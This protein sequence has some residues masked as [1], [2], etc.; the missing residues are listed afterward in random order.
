MKKTGSSSKNHLEWDFGS[1][2]EEEI[3][4]CFHYE[5]A[6]HVPAL[7]DGIPEWRKSLLA[8]FQK[9]P[10]LHDLAHDYSFTEGIDDLDQLIDTWIKRGEMQLKDFLEQKFIAVEQLPPEL[11]AF[12]K[13]LKLY[14]WYLRAEVMKPEILLQCP[15]Y[16]L[17]FVAAFPE[18]PNKPWQSI[19]NKKRKELWSKRYN[20]CRDGIIT[21]ITSK[22]KEW[23]TSTYDNGK[24]YSVSEMISMKGP[25]NDHIKPTHHLFCVSWNFKNEEIADAFR[26]WVTENRPKEYPEPELSYKLLAA[27]WRPLKKK[28]DTL[29]ND[30]GFLRRRETCKDWNE[31][32]KC[33]P[34]SRKLSGYAKD[35]QKKKLEYEK[36]G[37]S[38]RQIENLMTAD[39]KD[40]R[41]TNKKNPDVFRFLEE[42]C[43]SAREEIAAFERVVLNK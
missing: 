40:A 32:L 33:W 35:A 18:F 29:L 16:L 7:R 41:A 6:R 5:Y 27:G 20:P 21:E 19:K 25:Q 42:K 12:A 2:S 17:N 14:Q 23:E 24:K 8:T 15:Y 37:L 38:Q 1:I 36:V 43:K 13:Q 28:K 4:A 9:P 39:A 10:S 3:D 30:L 22:I 31:F 26:S 34:E 11:A